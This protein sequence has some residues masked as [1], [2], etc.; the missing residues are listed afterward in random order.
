MLGK[1]TRKDAYEC[2]IPKK[3]S[4]SDF[5]V[6][7][8]RSEARVSDVFREDHIPPYDYLRNWQDQLG[9]YEKLAT[10]YFYVETDTK[11]YDIDSIRNALGL[12][13]ARKVKENV[14]KELDWFSEPYLKPHSVTK[15]P[16]TACMNNFKS[17]LYLSP[18]GQT[19]PSLSMDANE[20]AY[21][22]CKRQLSCDHILWATNKLNALQNSTFCMY[23]NYV[24][25]I[26][27]FLSRT[28]P[29]DKSKP[30]SIVFILNVGLEANGAAF[31]GHDGKQGCHWATAHLDSIS[32]QIIYCDSMGWPIP[33]GLNSKI[34]QVYREIYKCDMVGFSVKAAHNFTFTRQGRHSCNKSSCATYYPLQTCSTICGVVAI[35]AASIACLARKFFDHITKVHYSDS[36]HVSQLYIQQPTKYSK[37][38]RRAI[39][40]WM[41]DD[42]IDITFIVPSTFLTPMN[43]VQIDFDSDSD[44]DEDVQRRNDNKD[45][46]GYIENDDKG[47]TSTINSNKSVPKPSGRPILV[48]TQ[49]KNASNNAANNSTKTAPIEASV[50]PSSAVPTKRDKKKDSPTTEYRCSQCQQLFATGYTLRRHISRYHG[51]TRDVNKDAEEGNCHC[52]EC[53]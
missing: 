4:P 13:T 38:L 53:G 14:S 8:S 11:R 51:N 41:S 32:K 1:Y 18:C 33:T 25:D 42:F 2:K 46:N 35:I 52:L 49:P 21:L 16:S 7:H 37:F 27:G 3:R 48:E 30:Q 44:D 10:G 12:H 34:R 20:L 36:R 17:L 28:M 31:L 5:D 39:M 40:G 9:Q 43:H 45:P 19:I 47:F 24:R 23:L 22:C 50:F 6:V 29:D 26:P 15:E